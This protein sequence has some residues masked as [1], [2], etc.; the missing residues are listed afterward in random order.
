[1]RRRLYRQ[2]TLSLKEREC[3]KESKEKRG[4]SAQAKRPKKMEEEKY[5]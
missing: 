2:R 4:A 3:L 5:V 1:M